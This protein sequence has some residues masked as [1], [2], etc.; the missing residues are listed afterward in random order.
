MRTGFGRKVGVCL[1]PFNPTL[2]PGCIVYGV[3]QIGDH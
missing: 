2:R 1:N 3:L